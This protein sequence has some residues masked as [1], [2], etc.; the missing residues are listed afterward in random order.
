MMYLCEER[1]CACYTV[2]GDIRL[3]RSGVGQDFDP[4]RGATSPCQ[5]PVT[6]DPV[7]D[8]LDILNNLLASALCPPGLVS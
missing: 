8:I 5:P 3:D 2:C 7:C 1:A 6:S 4:S